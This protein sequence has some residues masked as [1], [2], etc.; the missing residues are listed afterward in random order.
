VESHR[1]GHT[2]RQFLC[3]ASTFAG[4]AALSAKSRIGKAS[5]SAVTDQIA[6]TQADA[7]DF[8]RRY[9]LSFVELRNVP[10]TGKEIASLTAP[11][12]KRIAAEL[13]SN[14]LKVSFLHTSLLKA[15]RRKDDLAAALAAAA[16]LG[17][18]KIGVFTG[19]RAANPETARPQ[20][21]Q[22]LQEFIP[23]AEAAKVRLVIV[24]DPSQNI[25]TANEAADLLANLPSKT[26]GFTFDAAA[27][28]ETYPHLPKNRILN[29]RFRA[30]DVLADPGPGKTPLLSIFEAL[31]KDNY[32]FKIAL[33][34]QGDPA[35]RLENA[36]NAMDEMMHIAGRLD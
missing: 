30:A 4:A 26:I 8:A 11:E 21:V 29:V 22:T 3:A 36:A 5:L 32:E 34:T 20:I 1:R 16:I 12:L 10:E 24:P 2:R 28:S 9:N 14:K 27:F 6:K 23:A 35:K 7:V 13:L 31:Q 17:A 25:A 18:D 15:D 33:D 19:N